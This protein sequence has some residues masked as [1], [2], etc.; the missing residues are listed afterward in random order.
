MNRHD[1]VVA[2][3]QRC[4][5]I[6]E[7]I[8]DEA[9]ETLSEQAHLAEGSAERAYWHHGY[10]AALRDVIQLVHATSREGCTAGMPSH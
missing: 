2:L 8:E 6:R 4:T 9:P 10:Q 7:W 3:T 5:S 1:I